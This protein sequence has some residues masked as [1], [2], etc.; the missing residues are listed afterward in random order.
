MDELDIFIRS[1]ILWLNFIKQ[2]GSIIGIE[3]PDTSD[4][5]FQRRTWII[6]G[7]EVNVVLLTPFDE[8][9]YDD[10]FG[11]PFSTFNFQ[12]QLKMFLYKAISGEESDRF[13][14][15]LAR[16]LVLRLRDAGLEEVVLVANMA[17]IIPI[18]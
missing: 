4:D 6:L 16:Y 14:R 2:V 3:G 18:D 17:E 15:A 1:S 11:I 13:N 9:G 8:S 10:D 7:T 5:V 12:I